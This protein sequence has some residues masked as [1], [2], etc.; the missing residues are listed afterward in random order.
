LPLYIGLLVD[1][2]DSMH[3]GFSAEQLA[4]RR[5]LERVMRP[6][7]DAVFLMDFSASTSVLELTSG[8]LQPISGRVTSLKTGGLTALYDVLISAAAAMTH[9][10]E[11]KPA[12]R[13]IILLSDG[14]DNYSRS[15]LPEAVEAAQRA[16]IMI[17]AI[18]AHNP[19]YVLRGDAVLKR[20]AAT[21]G[22]RD[23]ILKNFGAADAAFAQIEDDLRTQ[24][25]ITFH[26]RAANRC[27]YHRLQVR[28]QNGKLQIRARDGYF[29]CD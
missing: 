17:Y 29:A 1:R 26:P 16:N 20:L 6:D 12:R 13:V 7:L 21:T 18:T 22:G 27:G 14:D 8:N 3:Q 25:S 28:P 4:A 10:P 5:F 24:Y 19:R 9:N 2:S 15:S 23:F 11:G